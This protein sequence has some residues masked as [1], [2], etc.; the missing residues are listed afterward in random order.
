MEIIT[1]ELGNVIE[2]EENLQVWKM[3]K[4]MGEDFKQ[5][6]EYLEENNLEITAPYARYIDLDWEEE[7]SN[8]FFTKLSNFFVKKWHFKAG[9]V[10][11]EKLNPKNPIKQD[12]I[13]KCKYL[14]KIHKGAYSKV[15]KTYKEMLLWAKSNNISL[16]NESIEFYL[17]DPRE[18]K[19]TELETMVLIRM[20]K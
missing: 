7:A 6:I 9:L 15:G 5:L 10:V 16:A 19:K 8:V 1:K 20:K 14:K 3:P 18:V 13:G 17:N 12:F 11:S 2:I 4:K